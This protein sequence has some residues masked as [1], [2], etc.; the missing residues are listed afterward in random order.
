MVFHHHQTPPQK[1]LPTGS[2]KQWHISPDI[3][4]YPANLLHDLRFHKLFLSKSPKNQQ[5]SHFW[6]RNIEHSKIDSNA[7]FLCHFKVLICIYGLKCLLKLSKIIVLS[8][9]SIIGAWFQVKFFQLSGQFVCTYAQSNVTPWPTSV[10]VL[11]LHINRESCKTE[12]GCKIHWI[13]GNHE[14]VLWRELLIKICATEWIQRLKCS[15]FMSI[16]PGEGFC[17]S[18]DRC[19][20][21]CW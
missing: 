13:I 20:C 3:D 1:H 14:K 9:V 21:L 15:I 18:L 5:I 12:V 16:V 11:C 7:T 19:L 2:H 6:W 10:H 4:L 8:R 17:C